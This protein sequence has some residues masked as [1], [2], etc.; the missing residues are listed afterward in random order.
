[1]AARARQDP[2]NRE[3]GHALAAA[4]LADDPERLAA[5][6]V[7]GD[8]VDGVHDPTARPELDAQV[9]HRQQGL[10]VQTLPRSFGSSA[11]RSASPIRLKPSTVI[12]I[13]MPGKIA[14]RGCADR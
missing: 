5:R 9:L 4:R 1:H 13:A 14:S 10:S 8:A 6:D 12:T 3:R 11:S 7:E 2:Q